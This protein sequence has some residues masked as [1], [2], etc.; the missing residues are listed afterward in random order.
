VKKGHRNGINCD[1]DYVSMKVAIMNVCGADKGH[2]E[3]PDEFFL[4]PC[5][6]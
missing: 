4:V 5:M 1:G 3:L 2:K 6:W